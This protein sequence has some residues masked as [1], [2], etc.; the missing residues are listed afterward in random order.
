MSEKYDEYLHDHISNVG[1]AYDM[2]LSFMPDIH[3]KMGYHDLSMVAEHDH[4]KWSQEEYDAYDRYFYGSKSYQTVKDFNYAWLHHIHANP[5]HWQF[6]VLFQDDDKSGVALE[7][8]YWYV[9]EMICD[10]WSFSIAK[11]KLDEIFDWYEKH[12]DIMI[13]HSKTRKLVE[14]IL[15][16]LKKELDKKTEEANENDI[17]EKSGE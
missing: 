17:K 3:D 6:W 10:W 12:K 7:M 5:H 11:G 2:L 4:S 14:D 8:P 15:D 1:K 13:L 9:I 16:R